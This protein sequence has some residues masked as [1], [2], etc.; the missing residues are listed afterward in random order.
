MRCLEHRF[1]GRDRIALSG[2]EQLPGFGQRLFGVAQVGLGLVSQFDQS[3]RREV[4]L[5]MLDALDH[6]LFDF[7]PRQA[8]RR[9]AP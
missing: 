1:R 4:L 8:V 9:A 7:V 6:Q 5:G 3:P 2:S